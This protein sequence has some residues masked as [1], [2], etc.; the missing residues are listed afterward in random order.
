MPNHNLITDHVC[1]FCGAGLAPNIVTVHHNQ[2]TASVNC[3][4]CGPYQITG[5]AVDLM[6][7][8]KRALDPKG[9]LNPGKVLC[10]R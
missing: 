1:P 6:R 10:V 4:I 5:E 9:I 7:T 3:E 2:G 8:I